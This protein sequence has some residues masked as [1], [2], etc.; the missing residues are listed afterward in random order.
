[1]GIEIGRYLVSAALLAAALFAAHVVLPARRLSFRT[2]WPGVLFTVAA[3]GALGSAFSLYLTR[4]ADYASYYAGLAG[5]M[6]GLYFLY[7]SALVLIFGGELNRVLR[8][9]RL[10]RA[11][12]RT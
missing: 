5:V 1:M 8:I 6:A 10:A 2:M 12:Q 7:L 9:R 3:W 4:Y 11:L